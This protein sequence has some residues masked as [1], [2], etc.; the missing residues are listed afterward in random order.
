MSQNDLLIWGRDA[1]R[2]FYGLITVANL[3]CQQLPFILL[4]CAF[5]YVFAH[6]MQKTW[7]GGASKWHMRTLIINKKMCKQGFVN[8]IF[9]QWKLNHSLNWIR[10]KFSNS[11]SIERYTSSSIWFLG[12]NKYN[13]NKSG[14]GETCKTMTI[15]TAKQ[16][17]SHFQSCRCGRIHFGSE[18]LPRIK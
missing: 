16:I 3:C 9:R 4:L 13:N 18:N 5:F 14:D 6:K 17:F 15:D 11:W 8:N 2:L 1:W 12:K 7:C 10:N